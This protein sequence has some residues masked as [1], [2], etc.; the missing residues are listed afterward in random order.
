[1]AVLRSWT[2]IQEQKL[3]QKWFANSKLH[4]TSCNHATQIIQ[5]EQFKQKY[6]NT[7]LSKEVN[8][9][10][11]FLEFSTQPWIILCIFGPS[12]HKLIFFKLPAPLDKPFI[13]PICLCRTWDDAMGIRTTEAERG[14]TTTQA[15]EG[16]TK[17]GTKYKLSFQCLNIQDLNNSLCSDSFSLVGGC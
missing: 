10:K 1:M 15:A 17:K 13:P 7:I 16:L 5:G 3:S 12:R 9:L 4:P 6:P 11:H 8:H 14:K 2:N